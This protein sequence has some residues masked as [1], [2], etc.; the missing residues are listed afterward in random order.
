M[1]SFFFPSFSESHH[2]SNLRMLLWWGYRVAV[3]TAGNRL[4]A[5]TKKRESSRKTPISTLLTMPKPLTV[6]ITIN[7]GKF[8]ERWDYQT[9]WP[10]S[11]ETCMQIR[12]Q[13]LELWHGTTDWFQI[14]KGV[15]QGCMLSPCLFNVYAE[16]IMRNA[17]LEETQVGIKIPGE[18]SITADMHMTPPSW[19]KAKN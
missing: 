18:I 1:K 12:K 13:E 4:N 17:G 3:V 6:G 7:S 11:W 10:A 9:T 15:H 2:K 8:W 5:L 16:Y 14:R 19:Q